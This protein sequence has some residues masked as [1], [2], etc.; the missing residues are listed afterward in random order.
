[1]QYTS[2]QDGYRREQDENTSSEIEYRNTVEL[3]DTKWTSK[4]YIKET[5]GGHYKLFIKTKVQNKKTEKLES[6]KNN[7][8]LIKHRGVLGFIIGKPRHYKA[9]DIPNIYE[10][11]RHQVKKLAGETNKMKNEEELVTEMSEKLKSEIETV[12]FEQSVNEAV[13]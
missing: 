1:M 9:N 4:I 2:P 8:M 5:L 13:E 6:K 7:T 11:V 12:D 10:N 3:E